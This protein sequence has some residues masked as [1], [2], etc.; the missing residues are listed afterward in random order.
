MEKYNI[1]QIAEKYFDMCLSEKQKYI[2]QFPLDVKNQVRYELLKKLRGSLKENT[3]IEELICS[4]HGCL[5]S[6]F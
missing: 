1:R 4:E 5:E 6:H 3:S 2:S